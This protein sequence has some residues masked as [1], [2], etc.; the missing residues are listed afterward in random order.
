MHIK[1][2]L[3]YVYLVHV[4]IY[5]YMNSD[6]CY[7]NHESIY[8]KTYILCAIVVIFCNLSSLEKMCLYLLYVF[9]KLARLI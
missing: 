7:T 6:N 8:S 9:A 1:L 4:Y 2:Y 5:I 3:V